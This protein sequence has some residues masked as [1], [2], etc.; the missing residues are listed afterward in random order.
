MSSPSS[1]AIIFWSCVS[2]VGFAYLGYPLLVLLLS[3][4]FGRN[5]APPGVAESRLPVVSLLIA[6]HNEEVDIEAR[7]RNA[8]ALAYP[9]GRL[10]VV[11]ASDGSTDG[12]NEIV[13]RYADRGVV[14]L[15][16]ETNR[17]KA[18]VLND[19][20]PRLRG[21]VVILSDANTHMAADAARRLASWFAD[22]DV[23]VVCY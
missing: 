15:A 2:A 6:A 14:L 16:Y 21:D 4:L 20:V 19:A 12:T 10:E 23:G 5:P 3:R 13:R 9:A 18:A 11:I 1:I 17:G 22:P 8:L 7:V